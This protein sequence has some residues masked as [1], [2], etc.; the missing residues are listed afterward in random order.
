MLLSGFRWADEPA[1]EAAVKRAQQ[2]LGTLPGAYVDVMRQHNGGEGWVGEG[3]YLRLWPVEDLAE[4]N[5]TLE[6]ELLVPGVVLIGNDGADDVYGV[7]LASGRYLVFPAV[8]LSADAGE[9][10]ADSWESFLEALA[11]R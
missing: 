3:A 11:T 4:A 8:G 2:E 5:R 10:L 1:S 6:A 7:E 9:T